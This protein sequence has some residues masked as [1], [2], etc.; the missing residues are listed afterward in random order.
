VHGFVT[1]HADNIEGLLD[2]YG[3][4]LAHECGNVVV[5]VLTFFAKLLADL[6]YA[7]AQERQ[8]HAGTA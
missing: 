2:S 7:Q 4:S 3:Q 1:R 5:D 8:R 6:L